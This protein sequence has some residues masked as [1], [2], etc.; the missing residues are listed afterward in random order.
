MLSWQRGTGAELL[1]A[2]A[3]MPVPPDVTLGRAGTWGVWHGHGVFHSRDD[4]PTFC[5]RL[6]LLH[7]QG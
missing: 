7:H 4:T 3:Q 1:G 2:A 5:P 6:L